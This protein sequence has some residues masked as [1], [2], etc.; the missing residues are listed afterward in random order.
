MKPWSR[1]NGP[2]VDRRSWKTQEEQYEKLAALLH[3]LLQGGVAA[4]KITIL[5]PRKKENSV[6]AKLHGITVRNYA[7][8]PITDVTFSTIY[9]FKGLENAVI[10][11]T[12]VMD[13]ADSRLIYVAMSRARSKL[14]ILENE[15]ATREYDKLIFRR[16]ME[17]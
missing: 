16:M 7:V 1:T 9:R 17:K 4:S 6:V 11:L 2:D 8:P 14:Y 15:S 13:Y 12:D 3:E 5:S 10:I